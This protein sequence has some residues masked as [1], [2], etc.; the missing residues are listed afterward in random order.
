M[1]KS[2]W[3]KD[4]VSKIVRSC[5]NTRYEGSSINDTMYGEM[6]YYKQISK[7]ADQLYNNL[8]AKIDTKD[9]VDKKIVAQDKFF[10]VEA[11]T[12]SGSSKIDPTLMQSEVALLLTSVAAAAGADLSETE[13]HVQA[14]KVI[15]RC[16]KYSADATVISVVEKA[17][18]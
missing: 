15:A 8:R 9:A 5:C 2:L 18:A 11:S 7:A 3:F 12:R 13:S 1:Y 10:A 6:F 17:D 4:Q 16:T 14:A